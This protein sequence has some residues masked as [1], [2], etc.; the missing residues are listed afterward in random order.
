MPG[1]AGQQNGAPQHAPPSNGGVAGSGSVLTMNALENTQD[2]KPVSDFERAMKNL[3]NVEHIDQP[4]EGELKLTMLQKEEKKKQQKNGK[5]KPLPPALSNMIGD[6]AT[7][8]QIKD[9]KPDAGRKDPNEIMKPPPPSLF[10]AGVVNAGALVIHGQG[11]PPLQQATGFGIGA[12]M[13]NG[14]FSQS[15]QQPPPM[16]GGYQQQQQAYR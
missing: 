7:L 8:S 3:V 14:G 4:A 16:M 15:Q 1:Y 9:V 2:E 5:S 6:G 11:P 13:P 10:Q 12:M